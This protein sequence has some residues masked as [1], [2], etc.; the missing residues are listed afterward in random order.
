LQPH[1]DRIGKAAQQHH[2]AEDDVHDPDFF[3]IDAGKP[4][5]P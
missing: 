4:F 1:H 3:V 5:A 2:Q